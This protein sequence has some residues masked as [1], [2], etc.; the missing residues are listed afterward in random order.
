MLK[1]NAPLAIVHKTERL[2]DIITL[3]KQNNIEPKRIRLIY[4]KHNTNSNLVLIE[5]RKNALPGLIIEK[6]L[7]AHNLDGSYTD[8]VMQMF[9]EKE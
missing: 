2:I 8:E 3:M 5:G 7:Y 6:P 1:N 9:K 4:P